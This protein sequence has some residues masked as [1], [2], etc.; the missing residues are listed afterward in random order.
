MPQSRSVHREFT[1]TR[2]RRNL[3]GHSPASP[4]TEVYSDQGVYPS[5]L[6]NLKVKLGIELRRFL[7]LR[8][9]ACGLA[10]RLR[11]GVLPEDMS[12]RGSAQTGALVCPQACPPR[13][14]IQ[15]GRL[16]AS[17]Q[18]CHRPSVLRVQ[19]CPCRG[20][21]TPYHC[22]QKAWASPCSYRVPGLCHP[23][24]VLPHTPPPRASSPVV[25]WQ[26]RAPGP[27]SQRSP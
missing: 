6:R 5:S 17:R 19:A 14:S 4:L 11:R 24:A 1:L 9:R 13:W 18:L 20:P 27:G 26:R 7:Q 22:A 25:P 21:S 3:R 12:V 10:Q 23:S 2:D 8:C 16:G 15:A